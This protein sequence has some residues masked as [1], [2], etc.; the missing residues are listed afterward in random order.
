MVLN[1]MYHEAVEELVRD[2][3]IDPMNT[4]TQHVILWIV[5]PESMHGSFLTG[6]FLFF[7]S[8]SLSADC[9]PPWY[10]VEWQPAGRLAVSGLRN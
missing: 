6:A 9:T 8:F 10:P 2:G 5:C 4:Y 1:G 7:R 3:S